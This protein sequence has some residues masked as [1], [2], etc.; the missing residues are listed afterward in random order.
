MAETSSKHSLPA[1]S[2]A[3]LRSLE[4]ITDPFYT[5]DGEWRILYANPPAQAAFGRTLAEIAGQVLWEA[6][7][8]ARD[9]QFG[10]RLR[11]VARERRGR[12][13]EAMSPTL[14][15]WI[16]VRCLPS[17]DGVA[18]YLKDVHE[19]RLAEDALVAAERRLS[20]LVRSI[21]DHLVA[22]DTQWRTTF[23]NDAAAREFG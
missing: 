6:F 8:S 9:P 21:E 14:K 19:R 17:G 11:Q 22:Y 3:A 16:E 4:Q 10:D 1:I 7:P 13:F 18:V 2:D 15:R 23:V 12:T 20:L 5:V